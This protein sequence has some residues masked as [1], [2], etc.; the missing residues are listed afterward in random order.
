MASFSMLTML[1]QSLRVQSR[2]PRT[3]VLRVLLIIA[4]IVIFSFIGYSRSRFFQV[5][6]MDLFWGQVIINIGLLHIFTFAEFVHEMRIQTHRSA[7]FC[8]EKTFMSIKKAI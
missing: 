3:Y 8:V 2:L 6:G 7:L 1:T 4:T 5:T